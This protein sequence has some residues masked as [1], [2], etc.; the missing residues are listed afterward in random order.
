MPT[1]KIHTHELCHIRHTSMICAQT[2]QTQ[3][4]SPPEKKI[5]RF[6]D[7]LKFLEV[8]D[9]NTVG[10]TRDRAG[11]HIYIILLYFFASTLGIT[12]CSHSKMLVRRDVHEAVYALPSQKHVPTSNPR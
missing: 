12:Q 8:G 1:T 6:A 3:K 5:P 10:S 11:Q 9:R 4:N 2:V 7:D